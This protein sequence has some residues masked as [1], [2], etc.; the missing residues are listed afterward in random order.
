MSFV[1]LP[2]LK[3]SSAGA[4]GSSEA[5]PAENSTVWL[6]ADDLD[7][8]SNTTLISGQSLATVVNHATSGSA[9]GVDFT[10]QAGGSSPTY[11]NNE[12]ITGSQYFLR[13]ALNFDGALLNTIELSGI[14]LTDIIQDDTWE[15]FAVAKSDFWYNGNEWQ[16]GRLFGGQD[17]STYWALVA[18]NQSGNKWSGY[19]WDGNYTYVH[20]TGID[21]AAQI[22]R[23]RGE[24]VTGSVY[25]YMKVDA[26]SE[27]EIEAPGSIL[28]V[29][30][31]NTPRIGGS[32]ST[33]EFVGK[34]YEILVYNRVL[35]EQE[36][37]DTYDYL[38]EKW[39][40]PTLLPF[41]TPDFDPPDNS[42]ISSF[43]FSGWPGTVANPITSSDFTTYNNSATASYEMNLVS[44][45]TMDDDAVN[46][47]VLDDVGTSTGTSSVS[48]TS[49][50]HV[51]SGNPP[52]L[53]GALSFDGVG[54]YI[55]VGEDATTAMEAAGKFTIAA[56]VFNTD[57]TPVTNDRTIAASWGS[58]V[59]S[60]LFN[61]D[62]DINPEE[63][64][65]NLFDDPGNFI[66]T[67][68]GG[69][70]V[71]EWQ[72]VAVTYDGS[73]LK[74]YVDGNLT[75]SVVGSWNPEASSNTIIGSRTGTGHFWTGSLDEIRMYD[76]PLDATQI[77]ELYNSGTGTQD[78]GWPV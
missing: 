30:M 75:G 27:N 12:E 65:L 74:M 11:G 32:N 72:H 16:S 2:N 35:T 14:D 61:I 51:T 68:S 1:L 57:D 4:P 43:E 23:Y 28:A 29:G 63:Y 67:G 39:L 25:Q 5:Q 56:W 17:P 20:G 55:S 33:N 26:D 49:V 9:V 59:S 64:A 19:L 36:R 13:E 40:N 42:T 54:D 7:D 6:K 77:L 71:N 37:T 60:F 8:E 24:S 73:N 34:V 48:N 52:T 58:G 44:R 38:Y 31:D 45:W 47:I 3:I 10:L 53:N 46:T 70:A 41:P 18:T 62:T 66:V 76:V 69:F 50:L 78:Y 21:G 22:I 15:V